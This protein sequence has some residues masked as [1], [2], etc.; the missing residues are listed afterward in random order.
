MIGAPGH[1]KKEL[2]LHLEFANPVMEYAVLIPRKGT[3]I[4]L[5]PLPLWGTGPVRFQGPSF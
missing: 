3:G 1:R 2:L 4:F 5:P